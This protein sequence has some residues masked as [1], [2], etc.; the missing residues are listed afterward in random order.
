M[1][2]LC[3]SCSVFHLSLLAHI[4]KKSELQINVLIFFTTGTF[5]AKGPEPE[6][7]HVGAVQE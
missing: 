4:R 3:G 1:K 6:P 2:K 7:H 5:Y